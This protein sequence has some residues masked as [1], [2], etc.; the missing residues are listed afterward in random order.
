VRATAQLQVI[1]RHLTT[2]RKRLSVMKFEKPALVA[3]SLPADERALPA[4]TLPDLAPN[5]RRNVPARARL[6]PLMI[7]RLRDRRHLLSL[8]VGEQ[9]RQGAIEDLRGISV[10]D[11]VSQ[12]ILCA[13]QLVVRVARNR[14]LDLVV[15]WRERLQDCRFRGRRHRR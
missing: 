12:Q 13:A 15:L 4:V 10:R 6:L 14:E 3:T 11:R 8:D 5:A 2:G 9:Q 1:D 7:S